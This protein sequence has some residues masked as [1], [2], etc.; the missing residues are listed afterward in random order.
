MGKKCTALFA[1]SALFALFGDL[2]EELQSTFY[3]E[4][5]NAL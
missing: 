5:K 1:K 2:P 4:G 3:L